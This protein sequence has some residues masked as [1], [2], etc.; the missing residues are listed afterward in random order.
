LRYPLSSFK[1]YLRSVPAL[2]RTTKNMK[3]MGAALRRTSLAICTIKKSGVVM[4]YLLSNA[5]SPV[6]RGCPLKFEISNLYPPPAPSRPPNFEIS[7]PSPPSA[8]PPVVSPLTQRPPR[9]RAV[10]QPPQSQKGRAELVRARPRLERGRGWSHSA[11]SM[12][13]FLV[14]L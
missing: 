4:L 7:N 12:P 13:G 6:A 1:A 14:E 9:S 5:P 10:G 3:V 11:G 8:L 2:S